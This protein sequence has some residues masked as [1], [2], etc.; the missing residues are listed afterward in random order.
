MK[1]FLKEHPRG[2]VFAGVV[3]IVSSLF[4][5]FLEVFHIAKRLTEYLNTQ[6]AEQ[7]NSLQIPLDIITYIS[8]I[9]YFLIA[10]Q[11][12]FGVYL[13]ARGFDKKI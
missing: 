6:L 12:I 3:L 11:I 10:F 9:D 1:K 5:I 4:S 2:A 13:I 8:I 7:G